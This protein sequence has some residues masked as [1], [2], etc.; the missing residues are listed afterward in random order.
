MFTSTTLRQ[1]AR[2]ALVAFACLGAMAAAPAFAQ[3]PDAPGRSVRLQVANDIVFQSDNLFTEGFDLQWH[4]RGTARWD[5]ADNSLARA[6]R[7]LP[8]AHGAGLVHR[9]A[10]TLGKHTQTPHDERVEELIEDDVPYAGAL[11]LLSS[12]SA[13]DDARYRGVEL[14]VGVLGPASGAGW[15]HREVHRLLDNKIAQ[16][17]HNQLSNRALIGASVNGKRKLLRGA[18]GPLDYDASAEGQATLGNLYTLLGARLSLRLGRNMPGGFA[19]SPGRLGMNVVHDARLAPAAPQATSAYLSLAVG[20]NRVL[21]NLFITDNELRDV[22]TVRKE[23]WVGR[24]ALGMHLE[25]GRFAGQLTLV[26]TTD[27]VESST[28]IH[29]DNNNRFGMLSLLMRY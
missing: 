21:R 1:R 23:P 4:T 28:T 24:L 20:G 3:M 27:E 2:Q 29:D 5:D 9:H 22:M 13:Y 6:G 14:L 25:R 15:L 10:L 19:V 18:I 11:V 12:W 7:W 16:G 17:W 26:A 8:W